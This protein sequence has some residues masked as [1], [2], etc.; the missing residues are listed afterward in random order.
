MRLLAALLCALAL[1]CPALAQLQTFTGRASVIDAD[2]IEI[3]GQRF[4]LD[5]SDGLEAG[6]WCGDPGKLWPCGRDAANAVAALVGDRPVTCVRTDQRLTWN[7]ML[8]KC[9]VGGVDIGAWT[10]E[11]GWA[12]AYRRFSLDYVE[13]EDRAREA[14]RGMWAGPHVA[15]WDWRKGVGR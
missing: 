4:R 14:K 12:L 15:P 6:Q 3:H 11:Q 10:V 7:R 9:Y 5:A 2:T 8:A 1:A 13:A